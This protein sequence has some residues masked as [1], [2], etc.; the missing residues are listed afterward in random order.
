MFPGTYLVVDAERLP[1]ANDTPKPGLP[2]VNVM[3]KP[4][5]ARFAPRAE[6]VPRFPQAG[7]TVGRLDGL[8]GRLLTKHDTKH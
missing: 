1:E 6:S 7:R 2:E 4:G 8:R 3:A 5:C